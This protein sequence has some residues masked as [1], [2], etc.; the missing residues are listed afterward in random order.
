MAAAP[1]RAPALT[2]VIPTFNNEAVLRECL[3][4]WQR[5]GGADIEIVVVEDGCRDGTAAFLTQLGAT[6]WGTRHLRWIH[7]DDA[8]ELR[9]TNAGM[10]SARGELVAAWQDDTFLTAH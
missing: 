8:H 1:D 10:A 3:A 6:P 5:F 7:Q 2:V 4:R 9:C